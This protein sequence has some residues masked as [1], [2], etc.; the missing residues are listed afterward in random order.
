MQFCKAETAHI[1]GQIKTSVNEKEFSQ[2]VIFSRLSPEHI[3][4][5]LINP[6]PTNVVYIYMELLVKPEI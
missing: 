2:C 6:W 5:R 4:K 1:L 3:S